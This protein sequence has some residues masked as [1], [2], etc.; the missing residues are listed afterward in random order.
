MLSPAGPSCPRYLPDLEFPAYRHLPGQTPHP[1]THPQGHRF[2]L[3]GPD[4]PLTPENWPTHRAYLAG[5]DLF[6]GAFW[7]EA[8]EAWEGPW[9]VSPSDSRHQLQGLIQLAAALIKWHQGN[10]RGMEKLAHSSRALLEPLA[11][12]HAHHL[13]LNLPDLLERSDAF[14]AAP[15]AP[16]NTTPDLLPLLRL[17]FGS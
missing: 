16:E 7:W 17:D 14:F 8:H 6:N 15:P 1:R 5:V 9:R 2:A 12:V 3:P 13:G 11:A 10:Q 4:L